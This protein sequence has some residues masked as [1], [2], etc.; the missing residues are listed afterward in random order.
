MAVIA[1]AAFDREPDHLLDARVALEDGAERCAAIFVVDSDFG[2]AARDPKVV[3]RLRK[4]RFL[5][6]M[7]WADTPLAR[8]ADVVLPAATHAE[9]DGT[10]VNVQSR[11][12]RFVRAYPAPSQARPGLEILAELLSRFEAKWASVSAATV[13]DLLAEEV[14]AF[15]GLRWAQI[16][17]EGQTLPSLSGTEGAA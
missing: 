13:F 8:A 12:Q 16:P 5:A 4:A 7:G 14:D 6:V 1:P 10:F 2:R 11:L 9:R 17:A 15:S 3:E